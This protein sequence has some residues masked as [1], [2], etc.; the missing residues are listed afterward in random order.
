MRLVRRRIWVDIGGLDLHVIAAPV[1]R[2]DL[3]TAMPTEGL[4]ASA[5]GGQG[6]LGEVD[7]DGAFLLDVEAAEAER[8]RGGAGRQIEAEPG[9]TALGGAADDTDGSPGPDIPYEP[10]CD[11]RRERDVGG[12][13]DLDSKRSPERPQPPSIRHPH[14]QHLGREP[15]GPALGGDEVSIGSGVLD[16]RTQARQSPRTLEVQAV[17]LLTERLAE[18]HS[19]LRMSEREGVVAA[20][21]SKDAFSRLLSLAGSPQREERTRSHECSKSASHLDVEVSGDV[22]KQ[23]LGCVQ[24]GEGVCRSTSPQAP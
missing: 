14:R 2:L 17:K 16:A 13:Q 20:A 9:L 1:L 10:A 24:Q 11:L 5:D 21:G 4:D 12:A 8:A 22:F 7:E 19:G 6:V 23:G 15:A 18:R 3:E